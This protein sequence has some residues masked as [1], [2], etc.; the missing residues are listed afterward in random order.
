LRC[1]QCCRLKMY[2]RESTVSTTI[3]TNHQ[4]RRG[5]WWIRWEK[6]HLNWILHVS[7]PCC[8]QTRKSRLWSKRQWPTEWDGLT[9]YPGSTTYQYC[10][11]FFVVTSLPR[12]EWLTVR[13]SWLACSDTTCIIWFLPLPVR[14]RDCRRADTS[15]FF[16]SYIW[17]WS[18]TALCFRSQLPARC[19][20]DAA[21]CYT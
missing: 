10:I 16:L 19:A 4:Q 1:A 17:I 6:R 11:G 14:P 18:A 12:L 21:Y 13:A 20:Y 15:A 5:W 3:H 9:S 8:V 7:E 2:T